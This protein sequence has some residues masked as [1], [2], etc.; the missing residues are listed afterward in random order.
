MSWDK[1]RFYLDPAVEPHHGLVHRLDKRI[2]ELPMMAPASKEPPDERFKGCWR[3]EA[4][5][6]IHHGFKPRG[7]FTR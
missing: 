5:G 6:P 1:E 2:K 4:D 7:G 3:G